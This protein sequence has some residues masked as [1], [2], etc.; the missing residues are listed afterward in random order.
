MRRHQVT[1][2]PGSPCQPLDAR[3]GVTNSVNPVCIS[4]TV[5]YWSN[6]RTFTSR[7]SRSI[8]AILPPLSFCKNEHEKFLVNRQGGKVKSCPSFLS[9]FFGCHIA[10]TR[11]MM[12]P[13][14]FSCSTIGVDYLAT[15]NTSFPSCPYCGDFLCLWQPFS[16]FRRAAYACPKWCHHWDH[17]FDMY[18]V[19]GSPL[20]S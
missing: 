18:F 15:R 7:L 12:S 8:S 13:C 19:V 4:T 2:L 3:N 17:Q 9:Y 5:P 11:R 1:N 10:K 20:V 16:I 6:V 14:S